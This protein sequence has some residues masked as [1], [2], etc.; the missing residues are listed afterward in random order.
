MTESHTDHIN[1]QVADNPEE[2]DKSLA[3]RPGHMTHH[4]CTKILKRYGGQAVGCCCT[5]HK[6]STQT[7]GGE[8][9]GSNS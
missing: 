1:K 6:C 4:A 3:S 2:Y 5:G 8:D 9:N 7:K